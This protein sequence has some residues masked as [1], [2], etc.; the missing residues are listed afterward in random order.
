M[1]NVSGIVAC[2]PWAQSESLTNNFRLD[3]YDIHIVAIFHEAF[4]SQK[5]KSFERK[6]EFL[7]I[8]RE[9]E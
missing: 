4:I 7:V 9:Y 8:E 3:M 6:K 2:D 5:S 1:C